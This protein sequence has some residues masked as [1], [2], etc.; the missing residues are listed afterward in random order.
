MSWAGSQVP[1]PSQMGGWLSKAVP[2]H[3]PLPHRL[4]LADNAH[5]PK[6]SQRPVAPQVDWAV[7][8]Q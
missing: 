1:L 3:E 7:V 4:F 6:P 5:A 8:G 2:E